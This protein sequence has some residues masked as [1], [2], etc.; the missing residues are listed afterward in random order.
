[1]IASFIVSSGE[2][3][4]K[5][6]TYPTYSKVIGY[7]FVLLPLA[8]IPGCGIYQ[9]KKHNFNWVFKNILF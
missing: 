3:N 7:I 4:I 6:I 1:M 8:A 9:A 2:I 5:G